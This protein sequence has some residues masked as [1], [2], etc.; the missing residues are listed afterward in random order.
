MRA[1][2]KCSAVNEQNSED[3]VQIKDFVKDVPTY[4]GMNLNAPCFRK[5]IGDN[6]SIT[7]KVVIFTGRIFQENVVR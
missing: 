3:L 4:R 7:A 5:N 6:K 2:Y 1:K